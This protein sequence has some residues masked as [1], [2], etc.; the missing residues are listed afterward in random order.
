MKKNNTKHKCVAC[1]KQFHY[2]CLLKYHIRREHFNLKGYRPY[3]E[4]QNI[5]QIWF[6]KVLNTDFLAKMTK[7]SNN[8]IAVQKLNEGTTIKPTEM[9]CEEID[10]HFLYPT[11]RSQP[12]KCSLCSETYAREKFKKHFMESHGLML[13]KSCDKC[14][15]KFVSPTGVVDHICPES[16]VE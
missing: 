3:Y 4:T 9:V 1:K 16:A 14:K 6:E 10:L 5:N 7:I 15:Q 11:N 13:K 8:E 2:N 12:L